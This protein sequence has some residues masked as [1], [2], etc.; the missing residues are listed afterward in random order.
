VKTTQLSDKQKAKWSRDWVAEG[1][2]NGFLVS[3]SPALR[4]VTPKPELCPPVVCRCGET[5]V[6]E[7]EEEERDRVLE[8]EDGN[9]IHWLLGE[10]VC[11]GCA[12]ASEDGAD[13]QLDEQNDSEWE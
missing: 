6:A 5:L 4:L 3:T 1:T 12:D 7:M 9:S 13:I 11:T 2:A 10:R 8:S